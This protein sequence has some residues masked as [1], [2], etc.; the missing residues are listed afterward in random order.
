MDNVNLNKEKEKQKEDQRPLPDR[1]VSHLPVKR[2]SHF[3]IPVS[4]LFLALV[5]LAGA[6]F[7]LE[8]IQLARLS[9]V[10][11]DESMVFNSVRDGTRT[12]LGLI[13]DRV[14]DVR[15]GLLVV[16]GQSGQP[17][18]EGKQIG[19]LTEDRSDQIALTAGSLSSGRDNLSYFWLALKTHVSFYF[20]LIIDN[21]NNFFN[22]SGRASTPTETF[23]EA[24]LR[25]EI[26]DEI[27][28]ELGD[29][30]RRILELDQSS[31]V[32]IE[33]STGQGIVVLPDNG[34]DRNQLMERISQL[35][36]DQV[37][38]QFDDTGRTGIITPVFRSGSGGN[39]IFVLTPIGQN[40]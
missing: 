34:L 6:E 38:V 32:M 5:F 20:G 15:Q 35:F 11:S 40:P 3:L 10:E 18:N 33:G 29:E 16:V 7:T 2:I 21:W 37:E 12:F 1:Y 19:S 22:R 23:D 30:L 17:L 39:Y 27:L 26:K 36:S 28:A 9:G 31:P 14:Q 8:K 4:G 24:K 25:Q 13:E